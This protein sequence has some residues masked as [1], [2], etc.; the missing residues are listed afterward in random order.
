MGIREIMESGNGKAEGGKKKEV[1]AKP[2]SRPGTAGRLHRAH[3]AA[4]TPE[5]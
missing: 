5:L 4:G 3:I 2:R 1:A